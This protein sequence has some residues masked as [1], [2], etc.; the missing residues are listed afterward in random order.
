MAASTLIT[1]TRR[2]RLRH[3]PGASASRSTSHAAFGS[4][5]RC[6]YIYA[7]SPTYT[8]SRA[9][10]LLYTSMN[11]AHA[12]NDSQPLQ[13]T[14]VDASS[15]TPPTLPPCTL[16]MAT[17]PPLWPLVQKPPR[18]QMLMDPPG[19]TIRSARAHGQ[20]QGRRQ[21]LVQEQYVSPSLASRAALSSQGPQ[22]RGSPRRAQRRLVPTSSQFATAAARSASRPWRV[23]SQ[24][25]CRWYS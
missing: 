22:P 9:T 14:L 13:S 19:R 17:M 7:A 4:R 16:P 25:G 18:T 23:R 15:R 3:P 24:P 6:T 2:G 12:S 21:G 5:A 8:L 10:A 20:G 11:D 1:V